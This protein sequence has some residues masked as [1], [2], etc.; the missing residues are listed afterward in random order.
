VDLEY[1][2]Y[3]TLVFH[4]QNVMV[5]I[6]SLEMLSRGFCIPEKLVKEN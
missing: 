1:L 3:L 4:I 5:F 6:L 2:V